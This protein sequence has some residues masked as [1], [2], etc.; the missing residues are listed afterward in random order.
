MT[1]IDKGHIKELYHIHRYSVSTI[2]LLYGVSNTRI[3]KILDENP[4]MTTNP[5][6]EC[7]LDGIDGAKQYYIDGNTD[8]NKPQNKIML[9]EACERKLIHMQI[10]RGPNILRTLY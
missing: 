10:R 9:C 8:N 7:I 6:D 5:G 2:A 4:N 1:I 3:D